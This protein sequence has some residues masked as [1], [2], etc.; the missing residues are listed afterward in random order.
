MRQG[1]HIAKYYLLSNFPYVVRDAL[2]PF[3]RYFSETSLNIHQTTR[4]HYQKHSNLHIRRCENTRS[5]YDKKY[6]VGSS[7]RCCVYLQ[8][9]RESGWEMSA[10]WLNTEMYGRGS[11]YPCR[12]IGRDWAELRGTGEGPQLR[13]HAHLHVASP[14]ALKFSYSKTDGLPCE[15]ST[16]WS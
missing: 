6:Y 14:T 12:R 15:I 1:V 4:R 16:T 8:G 11:S 9:Q 2:L 7:E 13:T 5:H 3:S 10:L